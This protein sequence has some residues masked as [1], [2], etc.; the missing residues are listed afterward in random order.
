MESWKRCTCEESPKC[1][2][3]VNG[4]SYMCYQNYAKHDTVKKGDRWQVR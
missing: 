1:N 2:W 4:H 3:C